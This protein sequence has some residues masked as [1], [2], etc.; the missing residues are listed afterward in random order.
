MTSNPQLLITQHFVLQQC[1]P[2]F[3][4]IN[5]KCICLSFR[6][7]LNI[8]NSLV[9]RGVFW[10]AWQLPKCRQKSLLWINS[11][12]LMNLQPILEHI[13]LFLTLLSFLICFSC[14]SEA[15][16]YWRVWKAWRKAAPLIL[17]QAVTEGKGRLGVKLTPT[18]WMYLR[19]WKCFDLAASLIR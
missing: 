11:D 10:E 5:L 13:S 14:R 17:A 9:M 19:E 16:H 18:L 12:A 1:L 3:A 2:V 8:M 4:P 7:I 15:K 6:D